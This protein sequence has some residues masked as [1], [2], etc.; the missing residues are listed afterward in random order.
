[1]EKIK[2][3]D[4][5]YDIDGKCTNCG[6]FHPCDCEVEIVNGEDKNEKQRTNL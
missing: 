2:M 3:P 4:G 6:K 1:M 5:N